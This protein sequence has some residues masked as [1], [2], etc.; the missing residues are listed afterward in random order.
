[1]G[2]GYFIYIVN[3]VNKGMVFISLLVYRFIFYF[4]IYLGNSFIFLSPEDKSYSNV[5]FLLI[6]LL[7]GVP[8]FSM[9]LFKVTFFIGVISRFSL[10]WVIFFLFVF[11]FLGVRYFIFFLNFSLFLNYKKFLPFFNGLKTPY[12]NLL[13]FMLFFLIYCMFILL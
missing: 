4:I 7:F 5:L 8:P 11:F 1:M 6:I 12:L 9:F 10:L 2:K 13:F 3:E